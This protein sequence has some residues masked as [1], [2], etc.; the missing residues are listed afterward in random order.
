M[1]DNIITNLKGVMIMSKKNSKNKSEAPA[2]NQQNPA[3][4]NV[5]TNS[6]P[7]QNNCP[8]GSKKSDSKKNH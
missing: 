5:Q 3:M 6:V 1:T 2:N 7:T 4:N 8:S